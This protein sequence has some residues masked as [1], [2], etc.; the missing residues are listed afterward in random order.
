[1]DRVVKSIQLAG[2]RIGEGA[3]C[4]IIAEAGVNHNGDLSVARELVRQAKSAG[5]NCVKFQTFAAERVAT[6]QAPKAF[7]QMR[8][9]DPG[10]SQFD[11]LKKLELS[12]DGH[13]DLMALSGE[14][15]MVFLS[16]AYSVEDA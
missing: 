16:T 14:L 15:G 7:Y 9:T 2:Q 11:M 10:E 6:R 8:V 3:P 1:M 12:A 4:F 5:A 13:R